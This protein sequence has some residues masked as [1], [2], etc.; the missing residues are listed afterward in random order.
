MSCMGE[1]I[2]D[3]TLICFTFDSELLSL[4]QAYPTHGMPPVSSHPVMLPTGALTGRPQMYRPATSSIMAVSVS[5]L[6]P[7]W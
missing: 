6:N 4:Q 1:L 5:I 7:F 2:K 3:K